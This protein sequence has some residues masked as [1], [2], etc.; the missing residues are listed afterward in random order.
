MKK[1]TAAFCVIVF[2]LVTS[3]SVI[4]WGKVVYDRVNYYSPVDN[5]ASFHEIFYDYV[6]PYS[7]RYGLHD[8]S[9]TYDPSDLIEVLSDFKFVPLEKTDGIRTALKEN[10]DTY[11]LTIYGVSSLQDEK[12]YKQPKFIVIDLDDTL[13]VIVRGRM[14]SDVLATLG[15]YNLGENVS[16]IY[17]TYRCENVSPA[18]LAE[19]K[20]YKSDTLDEGFEPELLSFSIKHEIWTMFGAN[21]N[22]IPSFILLTLPF[23]TLLAI[24]VFAIAR[25][26]S[27]ISHSNK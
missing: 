19:I 16:W 1:I 13:Y 4:G 7:L 9:G 17:K 10:R 6:E 22:N 12:D 23:F 18:A 24:I 20:S 25:R 21:V 2:L 5:T 27:S 3:V 8:K 26:K 15:N 11:V 14:N